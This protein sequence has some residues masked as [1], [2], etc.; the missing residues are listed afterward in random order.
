MEFTIEKIPVWAVCYLIN[1]TTDN[2]SDEDK[3]II[4]KWWEQNNVVTVSPATDEEGSSHPYFSHFPAF[5][6]GSDVIDCNVM[7]MK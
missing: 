1:G 6:L 3:A 7:M 2:L 4:D 5:G